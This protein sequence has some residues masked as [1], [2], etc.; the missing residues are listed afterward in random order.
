MIVPYDLRL[1]PI[2]EQLAKLLAERMRLSKGTNGYP[3]KEQFD[4]WC[5]DYGIDRNILAS[6]FATM[7]NPRRPPRHPAAPQYLVNIIPVMQKAAAVGWSPAWL[8]WR[9]SCYL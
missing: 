3:T 7:T 1:E 4:R 2:D 8:G 6:V 5:R 9:L